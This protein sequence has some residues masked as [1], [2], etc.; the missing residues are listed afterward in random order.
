[1]SQN[2]GTVV[3]LLAFHAAHILIPRTT[4]T[5][6]NPTKK[7]IPWCSRE[8]TTRYCPQTKSNLHEINFLFKNISKV[9]QTLLK[10]IS[11]PY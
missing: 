4:Y 5:P 1:M 7:T 10:D 11:I 6:P 3:R 2:D 8:C 9:K